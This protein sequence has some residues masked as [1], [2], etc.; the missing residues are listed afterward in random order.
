MAKHIKEAIQE[1]QEQLN[2]EINMSDQLQQFIKLFGDPR[3]VYSTKAEFKATDLDSSKAE[4]RRIIAENGLNLKVTQP[5]S[6]IYLG[7]F[8]VEEV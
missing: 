4:A 1:W 5:T 2:K 3:K 8:E 7:I 6:L